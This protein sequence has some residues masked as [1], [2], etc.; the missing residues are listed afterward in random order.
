MRGEGR[1]KQKAQACRLQLV[2]A[3]RADQPADEGRAEALQCR[4]RSDGRAGGRTPACGPAS[5]AQQKRGAGT[6]RTDV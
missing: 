6:G 4:R 3:G 5:A 2:D 1:D